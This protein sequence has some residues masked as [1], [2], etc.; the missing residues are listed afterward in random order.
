ME[1]HKMK[2]VFERKSG[3]DTLTLTYYPGMVSIDMLDD[4]HELVGQF[5]VSMADWRTMNVAV[6]T[7]HNG[8]Q[9]VV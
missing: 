8:G 9:D 7:A 4:W 5:N 6:E 1:G 3:F 2:V